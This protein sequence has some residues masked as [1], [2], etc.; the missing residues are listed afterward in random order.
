LTSRNN[1][2]PIRSKRFTSPAKF[3]NALTLMVPSE[4][5]ETTAWLNG[6]AEEFNRVSIQQIILERHDG[7]SE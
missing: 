4:L 7:T 5:D 6:L 3:L 2:G 1:I